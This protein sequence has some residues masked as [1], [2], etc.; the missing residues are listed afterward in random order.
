[1]DLEII[2]LNDINQEE[3]GQIYGITYMWNLKN[4]TNESKQKLIENKTYGYQGEREGE[5]EQMKYGI[6]DTH[7]NK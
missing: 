3:E 4:N 2:I 7:Y 6:N 1:M 5:E